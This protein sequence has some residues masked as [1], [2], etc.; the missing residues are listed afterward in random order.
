[1]KENR[2]TNCIAGP[3]TLNRMN[4]LP[5]GS[6]KATLDDW[7]VSIETN[8]QFTEAVI[9]LRDNSRLCF[10]HRVDERWAKA[11]GPD[12]D[13]EG[14]SHELLQAMKTFRLNAKHLEVFFDDGSHWEWVP[15]VREPPRA[16]A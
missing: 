3:D 6:R 2:L 10:C 4:T 15:P 16:T 7:F 9:T 8:G 1:M 13:S 5:G 14:C 11:F 12:D